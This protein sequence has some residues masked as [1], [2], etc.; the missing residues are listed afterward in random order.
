MFVYN[1]DQ[2]VLSKQN[3]CKCYLHVYFYKSESANSME[4]NQ[5]K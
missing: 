2:N 4:I 3:D 1:T 5:K